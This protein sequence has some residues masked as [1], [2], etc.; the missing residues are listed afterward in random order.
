MTG[1]PMR[2]HLPCAALTVT[3]NTRSCR[4]AKESTKRLSLLC[5]MKARMF[6]ILRQHENILRLNGAAMPLRFSDPSGRP[7]RPATRPASDD[8]G[9]SARSGTCAARKRVEPLGGR[10]SRFIAAGLR[11]AESRADVRQP[12]CPNLNRRRIGCDPPASSM[13]EPAAS[14]PRGARH[15]ASGSAF[16]IHRSITRCADPSCANIDLQKGR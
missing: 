15:M 5:W 6:V 12:A 16:V 13:A 9:R 2:L 3:V 11:H 4:S 8:G 10:A 14:S 1:P 7:F